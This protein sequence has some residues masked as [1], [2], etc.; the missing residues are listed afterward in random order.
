MIIGNEKLNIFHKS[1]IH[2]PF[3]DFYTQRNNSVKI[4]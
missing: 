4:K 2:L 3:D 1:L